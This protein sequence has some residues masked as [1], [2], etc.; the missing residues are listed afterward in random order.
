MKLH[1]PQEHLDCDNSEKPAI[2]IIC[3]EEGE[4]HE[5][6]AFTN[7]VVSLMEG[8]VH[9]EFKN[10]PAYEAAKGEVIFIPVGTL[11]SFKILERCKIVV[12][13]LYG[14]KLYEYFFIDKL[15]EIKKSSSELKGM[16]EKQ[17]GH[18]TINSRMQLFYEGLIDC[19]IDGLKSKYYFDMKIEEFFLLV[20][21]YYTKEQIRDFMLLIF[22]NN[23]AF[24]EY[25]KQN[26]YKYRTVAEIAVSMNQT[27]EQF[28]KKFKSV[29]G[30]S[31][32]KWIRENKAATIY[33]EIISSD[34][35]LKQI[36][37]D[38]G[39]RT[40]TQFIKFCKVELGKTPSEITHSN[41]SKI[42][43]RR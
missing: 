11:I 26:W 15:F 28:S 18:L 32:R 43:V 3:Y 4:E 17:I 35:P 12:F 14:T 38:Y 2:E 23:I 24:S 34:K 6:A 8:R 20:R 29:F 5:F 27:I 36:A 31:F 19:I 21:A 41:P 10:Y 37:L 22:S 7:G 40:M 30:K 13:R 33:N 16:C 42:I 9:Y 25:I 1:S 39:F